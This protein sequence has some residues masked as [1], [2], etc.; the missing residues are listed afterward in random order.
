MT[1]TQQV[2]VVDDSRSARYAMRMYL[3]RCQCSVATAENAAEAYNY[4]H[5]QL[6]RAIFLDYLMPNVNGLQVLQKLKADPRTASI[7]VVIWT[8]FERP[9]FVSQARAEGAMDVLYKPPSLEKLQDL[10]KRISNPSAPHAAKAASSDPGSEALH[11][12]P[13]ADPLMPMPESADRYIALRSDINNSLRRLTDDVFIQLA[14]L[15]QQMVHVDV[16][17]LSATEYDRFREIAREEADSLNRTIKHELDFI[18]SRLETV[19]QL[20]QHDRAE[21]L[22][23]AKT[24]AASEAQSVAELA[25]ERAAE[26]LSSRLIEALTAALRGGGPR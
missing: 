26:K 20:L 4:L 16:R 11:T 2:L 7:P 9:E 22:A 5:D 8:T 19:N 24:T 6:P 17:G 23:A 21:V 13:P 15:K 18:R 3:E 1:K 25:V 12:P 14:E 10:L